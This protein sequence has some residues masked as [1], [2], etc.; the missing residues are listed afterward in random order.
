M[1]VCVRACFV[2]FSG[3]ALRLEV[4]GLECAL[5]L[6]LSWMCGV[7]GLGLQVYRV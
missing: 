1:C 5:L 3:L 6:L 4:G 2:F 7:G